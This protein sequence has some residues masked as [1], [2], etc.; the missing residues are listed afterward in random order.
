LIVI[1]LALLVLHQTT[2]TSSAPITQTIP[3]SQFNVVSGSITGYP[4]GSIYANIVRV[5]A[6]MTMPSNAISATILFKIYGS[7]PTVNP[8]SDGATRQ[9]VVFWTNM[10]NACNLYFLGW[11]TDSTKPAGTSVVTSKVQA[12]PSIT[13][14]TVTNSDLLACAGIGYTTLV[15]PNGGVGEIGSNINVMDG[16]W[17]NFTIAKLSSTSF[18][19]YI[20][21]TFAF[22]SYD[23]AN[24]FPTDTNIWGLR[25]DNVEVLLTY[26]LTLRASQLQSQVT[27]T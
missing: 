26:Q 9:G 20:D 6:A 24:H 14:T 23:P 22:Q 19:L 4:N 13:S 3:A 2:G 25:L 12:N 1:G 7:S 16:N 21:G 8:D 11:R 10:Q 5:R 27:V 15:Q 18:K 17:H